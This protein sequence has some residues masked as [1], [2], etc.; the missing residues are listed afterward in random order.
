MSKINIA[1]MF[2]IAG[3]INVADMVNIAGIPFINKLCYYA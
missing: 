1:G 2:N 3:K